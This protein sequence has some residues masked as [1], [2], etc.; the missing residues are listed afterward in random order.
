M[1]S[2]AFFFQ[3]TC[4]LLVHLTNL[5]KL[6]VMQRRGHRGDRVA[7][8]IAGGVCRARVGVEVGGQTGL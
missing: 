1:L 4:Q 7:D 3:R 8:T 5:V 2:A 6:C